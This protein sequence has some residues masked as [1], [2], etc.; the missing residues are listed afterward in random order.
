MNAVPER[1]TQRVQQLLQIELSDELCELA[2]THRSFAYEHGGLPTNERLEFLGDSVLGQAVTVRLFQ[3]HPEL[4]EGELAK[5]RASL[6]STISLAQIAR[7]VGLGEFIRLG[8][9]ESLSGGANKD[10]ILADTVEALIG[11]TFLGAGAEAATALVER[12]IGP[13]MSRPDRLDAVGDPKTNLQ[14]YAARVSA[15]PPSYEIEAS[16]PDHNRHY[17]AT[18][19]VATVTGRG[20]GSSKKNAEMAAAR[21]AWAQLE[22]AE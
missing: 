16:G 8:K 21:D 9:G 11:A 3:D 4:E 2:L 7:E 5:R 17:V 20:E 6:V 18:V 15:A 19:W 13:V 22:T 12:L 1:D 14:E 10:S